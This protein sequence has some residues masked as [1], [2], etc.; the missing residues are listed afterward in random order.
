MENVLIALGKTSQ[1]LQSK[2]I[3][4]SVTPHQKQFDRAGF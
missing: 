2:E 3:P 4:Y 1:K